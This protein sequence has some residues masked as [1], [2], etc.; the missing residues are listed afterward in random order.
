MRR[1]ETYKAISRESGFT[2]IELVIVIT[3]ISILAGIGVGFITQSIMGFI[4]MSRRAELVDTA[5]NALRRMQRD[6]RQALPNSIRIDGTG[7]ILE[8]LNITAGGRYR[9]KGPG[10]ILDLTHDDTSFDVIGQLNTA[11][12]FGQSVVVYNIAASGTTGNAYMG[13]NLAGVG[14]GS[15]A[16]SV[17][18]A[19]AKKFPLG[20]PFQRFFIVDEAVTYFCDTTARTLTRYAGYA[21]T[22]PQPTSAL[23]AGSLMADKVS[24]CSFTYDSGTF[25]RSGM[26]TLDLTIEEEGEQVHLLQQI[27]VS[28]AP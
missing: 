17:I 19:P 3:I 22:N 12:S 24:A 26:V 27:H 1:F 13:D 5:E 23:G 25:M 10:D 8:L 28:N 21:I 14:V 11:P 18:L 4:S 6:V 2:L 16:T 15:T 7:R 9:G 20:S